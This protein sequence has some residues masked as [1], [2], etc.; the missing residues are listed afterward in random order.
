MSFLIQKGS[1]YLVVA[2]EIARTLAYPAPVDGQQVFNKRTNLIE[3]FDAYFGLWLNSDMVVAVENSSYPVVKGQVCYAASSQIVGSVNY[4]DVRTSGG[5]IPDPSIIQTIGVCVQVGVVTGTYNFISIAKSGN[6][7]VD[8]VGTISAG[9]H[10]KVSS[11]SGKI[12]TTAT[13]GADTFGISVNQTG[14]SPTYPTQ[15]LISINNSYV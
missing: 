14:D 4:M 13:L 15:T 10:V 8:S 9:S 5:T 1:G 12:E 2:D 3:T 6:Y 7:Y 11:T